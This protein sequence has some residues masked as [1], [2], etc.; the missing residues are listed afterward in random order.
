MATAE[1]DKQWSRITICLSSLEFLGIPQIEITFD[2]SN[3]AVLCI[4]EIPLQLLIFKA[5]TYNC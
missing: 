5:A 4:S 2:V 1:G 3:A